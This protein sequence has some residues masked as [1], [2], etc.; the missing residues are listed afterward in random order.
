MARWEK[1]FA[2]LPPL[3]PLDLLS[4][5]LC[6]ALALEADF[7]GR[8]HQG[9][10]AAAFQLGSAPQVPAAARMED[11]VWGWGVYSQQSPALS[12]PVTVLAM[13][14]FSARPWLPPGSLSFMVQPSPGPSNTTLPFGLFRAR[15]RDCFSLNP[16]LLSPDLSVT[17]PFVK[18]ARYPLWVSH[19][20]PG[21]TVANA[22]RLVKNAN[23]AKKLLFVVF[24]FCFCFTM[25]VA[26]Y[27]FELLK[28][29]NQNK[30]DTKD[31]I[32][33]NSIYMKHPEMVNL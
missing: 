24:L 29:I 20:F 22:S 1:W 30:P 6:P 16:W 11:R 28:I 14:A 17:S 3:A 23:H 21:R 10:W 4:A 2:N 9:S 32:S 15:G 8:Q 12:C 26:N 33:D 31:H 25:T 7:C 13:A 18:L 27:V 5:F 19:L